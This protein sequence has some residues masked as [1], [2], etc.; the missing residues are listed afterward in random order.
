MTNNHWN[1]VNFCFSRVNFEDQNNVIIDSR[2]HTIAIDCCHSIATCLYFCRA[3]KRSSLHRLSAK[4]WLVKLSQYEQLLIEGKRTRNLQWLDELYADSVVFTGSTPSK[5]KK[6]FDW[7]NSSRLTLSLECPDVW[8]N[9]FKKSLHKR[10]NSA[11]EPCENTSVIYTCMMNFMVS[12]FSQ[13]TTVES[14]VCTYF[15]GK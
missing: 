15:L 1:F 3:W 11:P 7:I 14:C 9:T 6:L 5:I 12:S 4:H 8:T 10:R 13:Q 2:L